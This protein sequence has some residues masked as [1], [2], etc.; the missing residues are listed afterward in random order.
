MKYEPGEVNKLMPCQGHKNF[1]NQ[2]D[3]DYKTVS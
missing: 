3:V 1:D 2:G